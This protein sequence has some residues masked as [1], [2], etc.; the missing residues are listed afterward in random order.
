MNRDD[1]P[2]GYILNPRPAGKKRSL[3]SLKINKRGE[4]KQSRL[5]N[6]GDVGCT[7]WQQE[8]EEIWIVHK[9]E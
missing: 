8:R 9:P 3:V 5:H 2:S 1:R 6:N 7:G 4:K